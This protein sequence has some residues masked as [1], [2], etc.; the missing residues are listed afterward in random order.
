MNEKYYRILVQKYRSRTLTPEEFSVYHQLLAE[1]KLDDI[2]LEEMQADLESMSIRK[3]RHLRPWMAIVASIMVVVAMSYWSWKAFVPHP[4]VG[5]P[6]A[7]IDTATLPT[8]IL[9][10]GQMIQFGEMEEFTS[11]NYYFQGDENMLVYQ[12]SKGT[13]QHEVAFHTVKTPVGRQYKIQLPDGTTVWMNAESSLRFPTLFASD[14]REIE[15]T[16]EVYFEVMHEPGRP[17]KVSSGDQVI[18]VLGTKFNVAHDPFNEA[19]ITTLVEG[20]IELQAGLNKQLLKPNQQ[21]VLKSDQVDRNFDVNE[22]DG[23]L[24]IA[25]TNGFLHFRDESLGDIMKKVARWYQVDL[26]IDPQ[27]AQAHYTLRFNQKSSLEEL[28]QVLNDVGLP[29]RISR[30]TLIIE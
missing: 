3:T 19:I 1:G 5:Y 29:A 23:Q 8:L 11:P 7:Q 14:V 30:N 15:V 18:T 24:Y 26:S 16:G 2:L 12:P 22:V 13:D 25:W 27:L 28:V 10:D 21:A 4:E 17:F 6:V 9:P 20:S